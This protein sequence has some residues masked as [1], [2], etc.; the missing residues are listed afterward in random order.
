[1]GSHV[2]QCWL[3]L[4]IEPPAVVL[5]D[6]VAGAQATLG[7]QHRAV[8]WGSDSRL[9][10][11]AAV[12]GRL[13]RLPQ[14]PATQQSCRQSQAGLMSAAVRCRCSCNQCCLAGVAHF[15]AIK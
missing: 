11:S 10:L 7:S 5:T 8:P 3:K 12:K 2:P 4:L 14:R 6:T 15:L 13:L 9:T 1:M